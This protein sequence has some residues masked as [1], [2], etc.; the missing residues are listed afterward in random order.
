[1][2]LVPSQRPDLVMTLSLLPKLA[3]ITVGWPFAGVVFIF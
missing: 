1:M 2:E 3:V